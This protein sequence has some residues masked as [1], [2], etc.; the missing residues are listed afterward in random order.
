MKTTKI[1]LAGLALT[2]LILTGCGDDDGGGDTGTG[3]TGPGDTSV[4]DTSTDTSI[5]DTAID[6]AVPDDCTRYCDAMDTHCGSNAQYA[7]RAE[8][9]AY[10]AAA[11]WPVGTEGDMDGNTIECRIYHA[12]FATESG[13]PATHCPHAGPSGAEVCGAVDYRPEAADMFTRIDRMGMPAVST[14][15]IS[16]GSKNAYNDDD[17]AGDA[18]GSP[19]TYYGEIAAA[20]G[21]LHGA[22]DDD[23]MAASLEPCSLTDLVGGLPECVGQTLGAGSTTTVADLVIPDTLQ[24]D[25][26]TDAGFPNGRMLPDQV[27]DVTLAVILVDLSMHSPTVL[28]E[29]PIN[30]ASNDATFS[31]TFP[32]LAP[33]HTP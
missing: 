31:D 7:D 2:G 21:T 29:I 11:G 17:P 1:I 16:G 28:A 15:L 8:C 32:Y 26:S 4:G 5:G 23:L 13:D 6:T 30:P 19:P 12:N 3:D 18:T 25:G 9:E 14:A 22:L 10:C 27:M 33:P 24:I 20:L